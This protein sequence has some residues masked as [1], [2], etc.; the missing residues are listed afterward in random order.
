MDNT[1]VTASTALCTGLF[2]SESQTR[3]IIKLFQVLGVL[4]LFKTTKYNMQFS[5]E[6]E[7]TLR[8][9]AALGNFKAVIHL[10]HSGVNLNSQNAMNGW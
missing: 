10:A 4:F 9:V 6:R 8:E 3:S 1:I 5:D 7:H 2:L